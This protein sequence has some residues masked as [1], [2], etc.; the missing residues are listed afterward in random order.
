MAELVSINA[1]AVGKGY[2]G[3]RGVLPVWEMNR[4]TGE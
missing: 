2:R 4:A 1:A 3:T